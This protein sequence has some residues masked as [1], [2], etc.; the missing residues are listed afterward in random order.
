MKKSNQVTLLGIF[1]LVEGDL[2]IDSSPLSE[3]EPS[4]NAVTHAREHIDVWNEL[5]RGGKVP[6]ESEYDEHARGR[7]TY[8]RASGVFTIRADGCILSRRDVIARIKAALL[9]PKNAELAS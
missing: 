8:D 5:Q 3:A 2:V 6:P 1:W 7:I 9:L 4:G